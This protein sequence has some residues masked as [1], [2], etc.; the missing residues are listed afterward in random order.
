[1]LSSTDAPPAPTTVL[2]FICGPRGVAGVAVGVR[3]VSRARV[4]ARTGTLP[5]GGGRA[6]ARSMPQA[7]LPQTHEGFR[8]LHDVI[9]CS[10][11]G[12]KPGNKQHSAQAGEASA[13]SASSSSNQPRRPPGSRRRQRRSGSKQATRLT[14]LLREQVVEH[15]GARLPRQRLNP[16]QAAGVG[17]STQRGVAGALLRCQAAGRA[18]CSRD[19]R[20]RHACFVSFVSRWQGGCLHTIMAE[21]ESVPAAAATAA[22]AS[23]T[24]A[25]RAAARMAGRLRSVPQAAEVPHS[26]ARQLGVRE[27]VSAAGRPRGQSRH[28]AQCVHRSCNG[29]REANDAHQRQQSVPFSTA[30]R[31]SHSVCDNRL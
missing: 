31:G 16:G 15:V 17:G 6:A 28:A 8:Q 18:A 21:R 24:S 19:E 4:R 30:R 5:V 29:A 10:G 3:H 11:Q 14:L 23:S 25:S 1:M 7:A 22:P 12:E 26:R 20:V 13:V 2:R 9:A 27:G